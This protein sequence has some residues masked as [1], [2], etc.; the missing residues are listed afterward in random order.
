MQAA[1]I[2]SPN[3]HGK[4]VV[5]SKRGQDVQVEPLLVFAFYFA[6]HRA[7]IAG[8]GIVKDRG[9]CGAGV[10]HIRVDAAGKQRLLANETPR[11]IE[12]TL[13]AKM[14]AGL[15]VLSQNFT[16]KGLLRKIFR[17]H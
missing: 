4:R 2:F 1:G 8:N 9:Q 12:A 11:E 7:A 5:E 17:S 14:R 15:D 10:F 3:D 13:D 16:E 6:K